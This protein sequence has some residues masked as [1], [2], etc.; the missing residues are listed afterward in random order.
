[1]LTEKQ[2]NLLKKV[3]VTNDLEIIHSEITK[4]YKLEL[5]KY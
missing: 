5:D 2:F 4:K 1:M 3:P